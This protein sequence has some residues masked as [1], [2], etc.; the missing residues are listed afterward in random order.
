[1][2]SDKVPRYVYSTA[3]LCMIGAQYLFPLVAMYFKGLTPGLIISLVL[4]LVKQFLV[5]V[6]LGLDPLSTI[7]E[8]FLLD[9]R[10]NR[11]NIVTL[12]KLSKIED[13]DAFR[14]FMIEKCLLKK[15]VRSK[16]VKLLGE[17][18]FKEIKEPQEL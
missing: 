3:D 15:R 18:Y 6:I 4:W 11:S 2:A 10:S 8:F 5:R 12:M 17:Y 16:L 7:D 14:T 13:Y 1:M 9:W